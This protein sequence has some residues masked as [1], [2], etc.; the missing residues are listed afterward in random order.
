MQA[1]GSPGGGAIATAADL[2]RFYQAILADWRGDDGPGIWRRAVLE[3]AFRVHFPDFIDPMTK[4]PALRGLGVVI[5]G[6]EGAIWRGFSPRCSA[7]SI[8][9]MGAGGQI[10]WADPESGLSFAY[11]TNGADRDA[12]RQGGRGLRLSTLASK[13]LA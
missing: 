5:A 13:C 4:Q 7:R 8:G 9:H 10:A 6:A 1:V 11:L 3:D 12:A 2:T